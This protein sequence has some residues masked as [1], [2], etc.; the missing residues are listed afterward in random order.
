MIYILIAVA[1]LVLGTLLAYLFFSISYKKKLESIENQ[2]DKFLN[3][4]DIVPFFSLSDDRYAKLI[5]NIVTLEERY[6]LQSDMSRKIAQNNA[7][8]IADISHQLKTPLAGIKLYCEM[9]KG[10]HSN[11]QLELIVHMEKHIKSLLRL[12]KLRAKAY[13]LKYREHRLKELLE[14]AWQKLEPLYSNKELTIRGDENMRCDAY[15]LGEAFLNILKNAC[16]HTEKSGT[17]NAVIF[18]TESSV[19][20]EIEDNGG[21]IDENR[22]ESIFMRYTR[23]NNSDKLS[24]VG[25]GLAITKA[26]TETHHGSVFAQNTSKGLKITFC[27]PIIT[28]HLTVL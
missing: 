2:L 8:F 6:L 19:F 10:A 15:W 5:N 9:D 7:E 17:I 18:R 25:L 23:L 22:L 24:G 11:K 21:G 13:E 14:S 12:E 4:K 20:V 27:F 16:Q 26:I 3:N 28:G 1:A